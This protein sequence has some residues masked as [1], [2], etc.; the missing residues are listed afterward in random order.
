M[1]SKLC[2]FLIKLVEA[3][4]L[5][6]HPPVIKVFDVVLQVHEIAARPNE[7]GI[8]P[9]GEQLN[10]DFF[11]M[12][13][14]VSLCIQVDNMRGLIRAL[15][16]VITGDPAVFQPFDPFGGAE[17]SITNGD[18]EV[19]HLSIV[20]DVAIWGSVE[21]I[22]VVLNMVVEPTDLLFEAVDFTG[23]VDFALSDG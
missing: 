19:G 15:A 2:G 12:S 9:G 20:L 17:N 18:V 5:L 3:G 23:F 10:G 16:I 13:N 4:D 7:E 11:A 6:S 1:R 22:L 14:H 8:K 21:C